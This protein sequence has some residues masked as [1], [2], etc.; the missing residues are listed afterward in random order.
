MS[1]ISPRWRRLWG[2][3]PDVLQHP[4]KMVRHGERELGEPESGPHGRGRLLRRPRF[5][6]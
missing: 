2:V 4:P 3:R 1:K 6:F 5:R